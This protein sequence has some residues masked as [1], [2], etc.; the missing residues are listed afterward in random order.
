LTIAERLAYSRWLRKLPSRATMLHH[1]RDQVAALA[2]ELEQ[3]GLE[4]AVEQQ[5]H[6]GGAGRPMASSD[7]VSFRAI[8]ARKI[9]DGA[10]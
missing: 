9:S 8:A 5:L 10:D 1:D 2:A 3:E 6:L 4:Q 7:A